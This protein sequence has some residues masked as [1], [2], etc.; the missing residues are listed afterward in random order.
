VCK[1]LEAHLPT[2]IQFP[3]ITLDTVGVAEAAKAV[4]VDIIE[5]VTR[6]DPETYN[7]KLQDLQHHNPD[8]LD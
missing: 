5:T 4:I 7:T 8:R 6:Q 3:D 1:S 2:A